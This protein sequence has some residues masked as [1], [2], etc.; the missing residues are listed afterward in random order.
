MTFRA[1]CSYRCDGVFVGGPE[2][3]FGR[4]ADDER[5]ARLVDEDRVDFVD[6]GVVEFALHAVGEVR[7]HVVAQVVEAC[8]VVRHIGDVARIRAL[9]ARVAA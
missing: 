3:G 8:L 1:K 2:H 9:V 7:R 6:D 5:S 4:A